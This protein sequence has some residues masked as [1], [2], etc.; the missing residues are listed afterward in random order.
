MLPKVGLALRPK[1]L[2]LAHL[3]PKRLESVKIYKIEIVQLLYIYFGKEAEECRV[4]SIYTGST[5]VRSSRN[6]GGLV[7]RNTVPGKRLK[8]RGNS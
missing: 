8:I 2:I 3:K 5:L 7:Y 6:T 4:Q 1:D